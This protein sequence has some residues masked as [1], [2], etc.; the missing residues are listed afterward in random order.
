M[1]KEAFK[2]L[3]AH[4]AVEF[5]RP[6]MVVGL[7]HGSTT[8]FAIERVGQL[9]KAGELSGIVAIPCSL[10]VQ[11]HAESLG[12]PLTTLEDHPVI[13]LTIDGA[14]EVDSE[15]NLIKGGGGALL[16]EK[17]VACASHREIIIVDGAKLSAKLGTRFALPV[18]VVPFAW[19]IEK[20][21]IEG[22]G[23]QVSRRGEESPFLTDQG[24]YILDCRFQTIGDARKLAGRLN[25]RAGIVEH[26]LFI[27]LATDL[28]VANA[29]G[30]HHLTKGQNLETLLESGNHDIRSE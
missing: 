23:A 30:V 21:F 6:G 27:D 29:Q 5:I 1:S 7:G 19:A 22:L 16:R 28:I 15:M 24:N 12:I 8:A 17:V 11:D 10:E 9:L 14:D 20:A 25:D 4:R 3:A 18:E 2:K 13:D 26:G